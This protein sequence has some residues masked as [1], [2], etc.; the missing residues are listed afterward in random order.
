MGALAP[1]QVANL[2]NVG[3]RAS[4]MSGRDDFSGN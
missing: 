2:G 4:L 1:E 3:P